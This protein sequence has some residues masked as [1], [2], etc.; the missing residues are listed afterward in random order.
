MPLITLIDAGAAA[1]LGPDGILRQFAILA[2]DL[3][4]YAVYQRQRRSGGSNAKIQGGD[5]LT[6]VAE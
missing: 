4:A 6:R 3:L 1:R 5:L 2:G